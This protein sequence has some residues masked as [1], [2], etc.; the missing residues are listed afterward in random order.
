[1]PQPVPLIL[2]ALLLSQPP[3]RAGG[4][5]LEGPR[6][7][8]YVAHAEL[9][10]ARY[11]EGRCYRADHCDT[12]VDPDLHLLRAVE[13]ATGKERWTNERFPT[14][15]GTL[16]GKDGVTAVIAMN[17]TLT[18]AAVLDART[19][20]ER[21]TC[22]VKADPL[23]FGTAWAARGV[24]LVTGFDPRPSGIPRLPPPARRL[25]ASSTACTLTLT[26][27][28]PEKLSPV[29]PVIARPQP[30]VKIADGSDWLRAWVDV[31]VG[32]REL[33][34]VTQQFRNGC[35]ARPQC[36]PVP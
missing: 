34:L 31:Q 10:L 25:E 3:S 21:A 24:I 18:G 23:F 8:V 22:S 6:Q 9:W 14:L 36:P 1:V 33:R 12:T 16:S 11:D 29:A 7:A 4:A 5:T 13:A 32:S 20:A 27:M 2:L 15:V 30:G 17:P 19:G 28:T 26:P 35:P